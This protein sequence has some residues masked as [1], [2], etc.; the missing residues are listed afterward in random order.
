MLGLIPHVSG[1]TVI[2]GWRHQSKVLAVDALTGTTRWL[3]DATIDADHAAVGATDLTG[4][5]NDDVFVLHATGLRLHD[6]LSGSVVPT[7]APLTAQR[8]AVW[9]RKEP[10]SVYCF[11]DGGGSSCPCGNF[12]AQ[13]AGCLNSTGQGAILGASGTASV[14][15]EDLVL[16]AAGLVPAQA[17]LYLQGSQIV[18]AGWG[19]PFGDGLVLEP[20]DEGDQF[21]DSF[22]RYA[23]GALAG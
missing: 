21:G 6:G 15:A 2:S 5:G 16:Q 12:A 9:T 11:G 14:G 19:V 3:I 7:F 17:G 4:D 10:G 13:G 8:A 20:G 18:N 1:W 23:H 22:A